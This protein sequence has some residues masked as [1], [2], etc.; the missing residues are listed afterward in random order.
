MAHGGTIF[1]DEIGEIPL[2]LQ[3]KL[4]RVLQ[5]REIMRVGD[6]RVIPINVRVIAATNL[7]LREMSEKGRFRSDLLFRLDV[8]RIDVPPSRTA[9]R[10]FVSCPPL[11]EF[12]FRKVWKK[13]NPPG[14]RSGKI[15]R[16]VSM[17]GKCA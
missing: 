11:F 17:A 8:L 3:A 16:Y 13:E 6:D 10:Y 12:V 14:T 1:L 5:E 7:N 9:G 2:S 4:L 15:S